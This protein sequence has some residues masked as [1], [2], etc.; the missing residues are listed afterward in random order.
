ML[1]VD[2]GV[3]MSTEKKILILIRTNN[4]Y[5]SLVKMIDYTDDPI[6]KNLIELTLNLDS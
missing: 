2:K 5:T 1:V 6:Q 3:N 4:V